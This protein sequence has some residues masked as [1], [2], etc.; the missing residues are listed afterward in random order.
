M[1]LSGPI[2]AITA[3]SNSNADLHV[4][5][6]KDPELYGVVGLAWVG[7]MRK[8]TWSGYNAGVNEKRENVLATSEVVAH[9]MGHNMGM[10][11]DFDDEHGGSGGACDGTGIMSYGSAP[12]VWSTCSK[13][14]FLALYNDIID[15]SSWSWCL[16]NYPSA[17]GGAGPTT[18][19]PTTGPTTKNPTTDT[20]TETPTTGTTTEST[21][22]ASCEDIM[23]TKKCEKKKKKG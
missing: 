21:T 11:H 2:K 16:E 15:S 13:A 7:T 23:K 20:T 22:E 14:D 3:A 10:L 19:A 12:N 8:T 5:L 4:F 9:E 6:C 17:C 18:Q 1:G